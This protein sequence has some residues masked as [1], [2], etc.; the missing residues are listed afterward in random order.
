[1]F[2][3]DIKIRTQIS[4]RYYCPLEGISNKKLLKKARKGVTDFRSPF[5][6]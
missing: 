5:M 1:L 6:A 4:I 2:L 3:N